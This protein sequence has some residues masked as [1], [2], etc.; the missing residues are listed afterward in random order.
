M[1]IFI[2]LVVSVICAIAAEEVAR[3]RGR[4]ALGYGSAGLFLGPLGLIAAI[5]VPSDEDALA[6]R[7]LARGLA[8]QCPECREAIRPD[9]R[10][11][12]YCQ[13]RM[14]SDELVEQDVLI[15]EAVEH[16][17]SRRRLR[18]YVRGALAAC[19]V[20]GLLVLTYVIHR[21]VSGS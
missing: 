9:A 1:I 15:G 16:A 11:C 18:I 7:R 13:H 8:K 4:S 14:T 5:V 17:A 12:R 20:L 3:T 21:R 6:Q 2:T 10:S 19:L